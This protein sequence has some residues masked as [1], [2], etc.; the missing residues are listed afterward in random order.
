MG[1][2]VMAFAGLLL[3]VATA[4]ALLSR[5]HSAVFQP[6]FGRIP[7]LVAI[8]ITIAAGALCLHLLTDRGWFDV[9]NT[10]TYL[11]GLAVSAALVAVFAVEVTILDLIVRFPADM[12]VPWPQ[13]LLFYPAIAYVVEIV[14][15]VLPLAL[16]LGILTLF[17]GGTASGRL[18]WLCIVLTALIEPTYQLAFVDNRFSWSAI[19][20]WV[21]L[22]AFNLVQLALF[23]RFDFMTMYSFR[24]LYYAYWHIV[25]GYARLHILF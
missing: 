12:N 15:H 23:R 24:L 5:S 2:Q 17:T 11:Q 21:R 19:Y 7:P 9:L 6:Y 13:S 1:T 4:V 20:L 25:W 3:I 22:F 10:T 8:A 18:V 14:F 16:L